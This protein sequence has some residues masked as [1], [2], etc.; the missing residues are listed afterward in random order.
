VNPIEAY[1]NLHVKEDMMLKPDNKYLCLTY[2]ETK[3]GVKV[4]FEK[5]EGW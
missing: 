4:T 2:N 1:L 3:I 5:I